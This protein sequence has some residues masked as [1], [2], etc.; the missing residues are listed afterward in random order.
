VGTPKFKFLFANGP[1]WLE[2]PKE[3]L[4]VWRLPQYRN[5]HSNHTK[6][7]SPNIGQHWTKHMRQSEVLLRT[8]W[9][10]HWELNRNTLRTWWEHIGHNNGPND[11]TSPSPE[12]KKMGPLGCKKFLCLP[13]FFT[14]FDLGVLWA[15][16]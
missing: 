16:T 4:K 5:I 13:P 15:G 1:L 3:I 2:N 9:G 14:F 7:I 10:T 6:L 12:G 8:C 11:P